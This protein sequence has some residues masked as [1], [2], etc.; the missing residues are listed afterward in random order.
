[1]KTRHAHIT[2]A[3]YIGTAVLLCMA[4]P[5]LMSA[6]TVVPP[7]PSVAG[8]DS[9]T[10]VPGPEYAASGFH[11]FL[12]GDN[13]RV[14]WI[15]PIRVPVLNLHTF[16]GGLEPKKK[17]GGMQT[18]SLRFTAKDGEEYAFRTVDKLAHLPAG[19]K[20]KIATGVVGDQIS[21]EHPAAAMVAAPLLE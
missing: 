4:L 16:A 10:I 20:G 2:V 6:Q 5:M 14:F 12:F 18:E 8:P 7:P 17:G 21:S 13:Y 11:D 19:L 9:I 15:T 1:M 3:I